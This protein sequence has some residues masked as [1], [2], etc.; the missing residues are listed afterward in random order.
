MVGLSRV[1]IDTDLVQ[2]A[3]SN[4]AGAQNRFGQTWSTLAGALT[5]TNGMAGNPGKDAAAA[6]FAPAYSHA[7]EAAWGGLATLHR[8]VGDMSRGLTQTVK[9]HT[10]AD[11]RS[12][13]SGPS[14]FPQQPNSV[15]TFRQF[16]G[17]EAAG[18][19]NILPPPPVTGP[20]ASPPKSLLENLTGLHFDPLDLDK[21]WP[22]GDPWSLLRAAD[23]WQAAHTSL[24]EVRGRLAAD[25][26]RVTDQSDAPDIDAFGGYWDR[27]YQDCFPSTLL[28]ALPNLCDG[29]SRACREYG[30]AVLD[31][32]TKA[33]D[34]VSNPIGIIVEAATIR[35]ALAATATRLLQTVSV[36]TAGAL[37]SNL[38]TSVATGVA[39]TPNLRILDA[40]LDGLKGDG[41]GRPGNI[42]WALNEDD[43]PALDSTGKVHGDIPDLIPSHWTE[44]DLEQLESELEISIKKRQEVN[45][46]LGIDYR[47]ALRLA[48]ELRLLRQIK[49]ELG[50]T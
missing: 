41:S 1:W 31:G 28:E 47:H 21:Y 36:I 30:N 26:K 35:A 8:S 16:V 40:E 20:G 17:L 49:K 34:A 11:R 5:P 15:P 4:V 32:Q 46:Q 45:D 3:A 24:I 10:K 19:L 12:M 23:A 2:T 29:I 39:D 13:I 43:V 38:I 42:V 48:Q 7:A 44:E 27:I 6:K 9:N 50:G 14:P 33:S 22:T 25:L 18:P 37:A